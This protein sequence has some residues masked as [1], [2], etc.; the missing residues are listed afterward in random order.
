MS[1]N[2]QSVVT[3]LF[4]WVFGNL[5]HFNVLSFDVFLVI[6][7]LTI[8]GN[9]LIIV[10]VTTCRVLHSPMYYF[11]CHLSVGDI[12]LSVNIVPNI[13]RA[14]L[15][16]GAKISYPGCIIQLYFYSGVIITEC[17]LLSVM[18]YD[19]NMAF[20]FQLHYTSIMDHR[21]CIYLSTWP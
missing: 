15:M 14:S 3:E 18:S 9:L 19:R 1:A 21:T 8:T 20:C 11:L 7:G 12:L 2:N 6:F 4:L 10:L 13:L 17:F 5:P 16:G